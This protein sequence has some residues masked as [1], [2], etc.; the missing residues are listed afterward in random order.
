MSCARFPIFHF[1]CLRVQKYQWT[2]ILV[3]LRFE[4]FRDKE[5]IHEYF[6]NPKGMKDYGSKNISAWKVDA[7]NGDKIAQ[8]LLGTILNP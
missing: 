6:V 8:A 3:L 5:L 1:F 7:Q 4:C 2:R